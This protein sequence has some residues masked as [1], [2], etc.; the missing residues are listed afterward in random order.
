MNKDDKY[1]YRVVRLIMIFMII[2]IIA[3]VVVGLARADYIVL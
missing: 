3:L 2:W 1:S